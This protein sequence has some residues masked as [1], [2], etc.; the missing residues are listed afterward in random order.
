MLHVTCFGNS[1]E[2]EPDRTHSDMLRSGISLEEHNYLR[3]QAGRLTYLRDAK[4]E[5]RMYAEPRDG[6]LRLD[7]I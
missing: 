2:T 6:E 4:G 5:S 3:T 7:L 1:L